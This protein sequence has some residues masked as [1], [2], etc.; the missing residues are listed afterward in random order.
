MRRRRLPARAVIVSPRESTS[1][2]RDG[3]VRRRS[4]A[5]EENGVAT[6]RIEVEVANFYPAIASEISMPAYQ[7]TQS[8]IHVLVTQSF[9]RSLATLNLAESK[10]GRLAA[11]EAGAARSSQ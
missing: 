8:V 4:R 3:D 7:A 2:A 6:L 5:A 11:A 9:L 10:V 1:V